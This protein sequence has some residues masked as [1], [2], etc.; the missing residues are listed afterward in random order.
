[1]SLGVAGVLATVV[2]DDARPVGPQELFLRQPGGA[3]F[4]WDSTMGSNGFRFLLTLNP[5]DT[6]AGVA[7]YTG[8]DRADVLFR[9]GSGSFITWDI[10]RGGAG[11]ASLTSLDGLQIVGSGDLAGGFGQDLLALAPNRDLKI[12]DGAS[13]M[14]TDV[15]RMAPGF[16]VA[17]VGN[18]D[19]VGRDD[20][21]FLND[22]SRALFALTD[23]GWRDLF[24]MGNGWQLQG[25]A[26]VIDGPED[27]LVLFNTNSRVSIFWNPTQGGAGW[28][29]F[30]TLGNGWSFEA[31]ADF[32][33]YARDDVA[34]R[35]VNG[36]AIYWTGSS[37]GSLGNVL[38][39]VQLVG[40]ADLG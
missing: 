8:D 30:V 27:D 21:L 13:N 38:G 31:L 40:V 37:W 10:S 17:G 16:R 26:N 4:A 5:A 11:F 6:V 2:N 22:S 12:I 1:M 7:D 34:F 32:N 28:R 23:S 36:D 19:G 35:N 9:L 3:L 24:T 14:V 25:L 33:G 18:I 29:D 20:I 15:L 39:A